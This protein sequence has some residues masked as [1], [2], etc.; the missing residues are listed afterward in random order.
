MEDGST[1]ATYALAG[2]GAF[3]NPSGN[4]PF[5]CFDTPVDYCVS[6][7]GYAY[8]ITS[9]GGV[10]FHFPSTMLP[11]FKAA[12]KS[13]WEMPATAKGGNVAGDVPPGRRRGH[14]LRVDKDW[15][16]I[17]IGVH[18]SPSSH[19]FYAPYSHIIGDPSAIQ[20]NAA[21]DFEPHMKRVA[22]TDGRTT[23]FP[24]A[25]LITPAGMP[26]HSNRTVPNP[27]PAASERGIR[28][29][30]ERVLGRKTGICAY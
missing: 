2:D 7:S 8:D 11:R 17:L 23:I 19:R 16:Q 22:L 24:L 30:V 12:M 26:I 13:V 25:T 27:H 4:R 3:R 9:L 21:V 15:N 10:P 14:V 20:P 29:H 1:A 28:G 18:G 5:M 6:S